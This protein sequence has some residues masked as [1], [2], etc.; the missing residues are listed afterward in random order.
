VGGVVVQLVF[1]KAPRNQ[2]RFWFT[3]FDGVPEEI[4]CPWFWPKHLIVLVPL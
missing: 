4:P 2:V 3:T 1:L